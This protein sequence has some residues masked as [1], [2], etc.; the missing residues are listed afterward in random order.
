VAVPTWLGKNWK[1]MLVILTVF[2]LIIHSLIPADV[3]IWSLVGK[4][5]TGG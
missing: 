3:T 2:F 1:S 4:F 5:F